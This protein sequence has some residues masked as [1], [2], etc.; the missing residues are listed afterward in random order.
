MAQ[1]IGALISA[2]GAYSASQ[3]QKKSAQAYA[4]AQGPLGDIQAKTAKDLQPY[5]SGF[6]QRAQ[7]AFDPSF[8]YYRALLSGNRAD[9]LTA[10]SPQVRGVNARYQQLTAA[11]REL[12]PR[13]GASASFNA[14]LP[15]QRNSEINSLISAA[16]GVGAQG[17]SALAG[18]AGSLGSGA[19]G[20]M[21]ANAQGAS[22]IANSLFNA[23]ANANASTSM[24]YKSI[25]DAIT[26]AYDEYNK[27]KT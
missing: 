10:L 14:Q 11:Q 9:L 22:G 7:D 16:P 20:G 5:A 25:A 21:V 18:Q 2:Y 3:S 23:N 12:S 13:G 4:G 26:S 6:Y 8:S 19:A 15:Y 17:L 24:Y 1:I 27:R